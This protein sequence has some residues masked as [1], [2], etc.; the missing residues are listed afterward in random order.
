MRAGVGQPLAV[1]AAGAGRAA[2]AARRLL[3]LEKM[4][5]L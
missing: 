3:P 5:S 2:G 1:G 4:P